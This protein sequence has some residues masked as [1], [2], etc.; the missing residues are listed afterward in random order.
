MS[1]EDSNN[2]I[3]IRITV[4]VRITVRIRNPI[5]ITVHVYQENYVLHCC[6]Q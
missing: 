1:S 2:P 6:Y 4:R 5:R 3:R